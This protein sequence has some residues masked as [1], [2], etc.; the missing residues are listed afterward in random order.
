MNVLY[1][2][3]PLWR[4]YSAQG[5][6]ARETSVTGSEVRGLWERGRQGGEPG[7]SWLKHMSIRKCFAH[8]VCEVSGLWFKVMGVLY[9]MGNVEMARKAS[10]ERAR[11][12]TRGRVFYLH[13]LEFRCVA[14]FSLF[15]DIV[16]TL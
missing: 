2:A 16:F 13:I 9:K 5:C 10:G 15:L 7:P 12:R 14:N 8:R 4:R 11:E 6:G 3:V 1:C